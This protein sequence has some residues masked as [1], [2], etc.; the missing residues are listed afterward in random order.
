MSKTIETKCVIP[1]FPGFYHTIIDGDDAIEYNMEYMV[2]QGEILEGEEP[3]FD[4][5]FDYPAY[6]KSV[7]ADY[8]VYFVEAI[9]EAIEE[10]AGESLNFILD[11]EREDEIDTFSPREY[12]F[13]NDQVYPIY[14]FDVDSVLR[15]LDSIK[16]KADVSYRL[17]NDEEITLRNQMFDGYAAR[18]GFLPNVSNDI[19][20][21]FEAI[22]FFLKKRERSPDGEGEPMDLLLLLIHHLS[23]LMHGG[24]ANWQ[25]PLSYLNVREKMSGNGELDPFNFVKEPSYQVWHYS[26]ENSEISLKCRLSAIS[27]GNA[28]HLAAKEGLIETSHGK[29]SDI[30]KDGYFAVKIWVARVRGRED[31][32]RSYTVEYRDESST[33]EK[34]GLKKDVLKSSPIKTLLESGVKP[35]I[36]AQVKAVQYLAS[37]WDGWLFGDWAIHNINKNSFIVVEKYL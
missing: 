31:W 18:D 23:A 28:L 6:K 22:E 1:G 26:K 10:I 20:D 13:H 4:I 36:E 34:V 15:I 8:A 21:W 7:S 25:N 9:E 3:F 37:G 5:D 32:S 30:I 11:Y 35:T 19:E 12:N 2:E 14:K 33:A 29:A 17:S 27:E 24:T 16:K